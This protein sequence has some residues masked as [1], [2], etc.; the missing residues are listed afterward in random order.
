MVGTAVLPPALI[1]CAPEENTKRVAET[2]WKFN[3]IEPSDA[4]EVIV[5]EGLEWDLLVK[6]EDQISDNDKFGSH[7]DYLA[8]LPDENNPDEGLLW[9]NNEHFSPRLSTAFDGEIERTKEDVDF[10]MYQVGGSIIKVKKNQAGKWEMVVNDSHNRRLTAHTEI[11]FNWSEQ[12]YGS[13][14]AIGTNG[15]CAGGITPWGT[16]FTCEENYHN[17]WGERDLET[18]ERTNS[19]LKWHH[20]YDYPPEH[21]GWVV[22]VDPRTGDAKKHVALGRCAHECATI[23][24]LDDGRF[25]VYTGDD[26]R[27][28]CLYKFISS[29]PGSL[30]NGTLYVA[31]TDEGRW[32]SL[33]YDTQEVLQQNFK[34]QT[35][36]LTYLRKAAKLVGGSPLDRPEDIE[37][38]PLTGNVLVALTKNYPAGNYYGQI[39]KVEEGEGKYDSL[40]FTSEAF[41]AGGEETGFAAPDN[42]EFDKAGNLWFTCDVPGG[43]MNNEEIPQYLPFKNNALFVLMR[44]GPQSGEVIRVASAPTDAEFTGPFFSPDGKTLFLSVQHPGERS[45]S[46]DELTSHWPEGG[47]ALPRSGVITLQGE[48]LEKIQGLA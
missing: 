23:V 40:S 42:M 26:K 46:K 11:P 3:G 15:N 10:E 9:V 13:N 21:Y 33:D 34:N 41:L 29:E 12:I 36:V 5:A 39:M 19:W 8:F 28:E 6:W 37:I 48:T 24:V 20:I 35:E 7:N 4:D 32:I 27:G 14:T 22:E 17:Y 43:H 16:I 2:N 47:D 1:A 38:D 45:R 25:V 44:N 30:E 18:G 31:N